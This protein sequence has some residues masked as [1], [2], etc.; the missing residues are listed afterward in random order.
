MPDLLHKLWQVTFHPPR[1]AGT[2]FFFFFWNFATSL[3]CSFLSFGIRNC[4]C[5][6]PSICR[7]NYWL[8]KRWVRL[9]LRKNYYSRGVLLPT[10][11]KQ[12]PCGPAMQLAIQFYSTWHNPVG[13]VENAKPL[14]PEFITGLADAEGCF[15]YCYFSTE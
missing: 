15:L 12:F 8:H 14:H 5:A 4:S 11:F 13:L 6:K 1:G 7:S 10:E 3:H 2:I 9:A